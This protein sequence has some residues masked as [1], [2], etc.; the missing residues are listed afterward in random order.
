MQ[1]CDR[2]RNK[3]GQGET[4]TRKTKGKA[5]QTV[6][7][8]GKRVV[9]RK[10]FVRAF[11]RHGR[12][13]EKM[14]VPKSGVFGGETV[15]SLEK[16]A[17]YRAEQCHCQAYNK[18]ERGELQGKLYDAQRQQDNHHRYEAQHPEA[19]KRPP[20]DYVELLRS[21]DANKADVRQFGEKCTSSGYGKRKELV[22]DPE[23]RAGGSLQTE[24]KNVP[25]QG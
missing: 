8:L 23:V 5:R 2:Q 25:C 21:C 3:A 14:E 6:A 7:E 10:K 20:V 24:E 1:A 12:E 17:Q 13:K 9:T 11:K 19:V 15:G 18:G 22:V 16:C 4:P